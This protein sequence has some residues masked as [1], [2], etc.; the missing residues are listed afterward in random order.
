MISSLAFEPINAANRFIVDYLRS[1][2]VIISKMQ[3]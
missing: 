1:I 2:A 3:N